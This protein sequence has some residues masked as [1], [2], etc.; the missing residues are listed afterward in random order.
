[1]PLPIVS[2][3]GTLRITPQTITWIPSTSDAGFKA[4]MRPG[5]VLIRVH[6]GA[7]FDAKGRQFSGTLTGILGVTGQVLS[8]G[9]FESWFLVT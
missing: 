9:T 1:V 6:C 4:T 3:F 8:G 5:R 7:L 2:L